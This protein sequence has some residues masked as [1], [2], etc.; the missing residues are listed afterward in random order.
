MDAGKSCL[1]DLILR[2]PS[3]VLPCL[4]LDQI[5]KVCR[6]LFAGFLSACVLGR[7]E[8]DSVNVSIHQAEMMRNSSFGPYDPTEFSPPDF[9]VVVIALFYASLW[10]APSQRPLQCSSKAGYADTTVAYRRCQSQSHGPKR[11]NFAT[12]ARSAG[13]LQWLRCSNLSSRCL[14]SYL[15]SA[16]GYSFSCQYVLISRDHCHFWC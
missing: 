9:I 7:F 11:V 14:L 3:Y 2:S 10:V 4:P 8:P 5:N 12:P 6:A 15:P 13:G 16:L 1:D